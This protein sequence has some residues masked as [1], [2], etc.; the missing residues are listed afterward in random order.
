MVQAPALHLQIIRGK[1]ILEGIEEEKAP[2][3]S[4]VSSDG[5]MT[6]Q[7]SSP[8]GGWI[9]FTNVSGQREG[10]A[11][12]M[13][14]RDGESRTL[15]ELY[16]ENSEVQ[17]MVTSYDPETGKMIYKGRARNGYLEGKVTEFPEGSF[18][19]IFML[20]L[21]HGPAT[22]NGEKRMYRHG[23]DIT[24]NTELWPASSRKDRVDDE[25]EQL[26]AKRKELEKK[27]EELDQKKKE[28]AEREAAAA[29]KKERLEKDEV[30]LRKRKE[31]ADRAMKEAERTKEAWEREK[32]AAEEEIPKGSCC[33]SVM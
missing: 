32:K 20:G 3:E 13:V 8:A 16:Y 28:V 31:S 17:G 21:K 22:E 26:E 19:G 10:E 5:R 12:V 30:E 9:E 14:K 6:V 25:K 1:R 24:Q 15:F 7:L 23:V 29:A 4:S 11:K 18:E 2:D 33:C 27:K